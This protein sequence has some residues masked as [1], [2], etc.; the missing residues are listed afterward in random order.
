M[1]FYFL[2]VLKGIFGEVFK[3]LIVNKSLWYRKFLYNLGIIF[4]NGKVVRVKND[5]KG[6][7]KGIWYCNIGNLLISVILISIKY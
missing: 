3:W 1:Y 2:L 7:V 4:F 5:I 6:V